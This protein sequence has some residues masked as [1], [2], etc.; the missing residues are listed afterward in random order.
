MKTLGMLLAGA[1]L[2]GSAHAA[3][4]QYEYTA[5]IQE[6]L[7]FSPSTGSGG[8]IDSASLAGDTVAVGDIV[9][10]HFSYDT[11]TGVFGDFGAGPVYSS[12]TA[13]N[14]VSAY[15]SGHNFALSAPTN[16]STMVQVTNNA[17]LLGGGDNLSIG[18]VSENDDAQQLLVVNFFDQ[19]GLALS[20]NNIPG[21]IDAGAFSQ[22]TFYYLYTTKGNH[23]MLGANGQLTSLTLISSV[24]EAQ[25]YG[26]LLSGLGILG[27]LSRRRKQHSL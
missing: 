25:T 2:C 26:M 4:Y 1:A 19:S 18:N 27:F 6:M 20:D 14:S 3:V 23:D 7:Q 9:F 8:M 5:T 16:S 12:S 11:E 13:A 22:S 21:A 10:G 15:S 17:T 24:P